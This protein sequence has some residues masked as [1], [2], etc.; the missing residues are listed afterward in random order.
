ML[1]RAAVS[2]LILAVGSGVLVAASSMRDSP[3]AQTPTS[4]QTYIAR[5]SPA[6]S[7]SSP[8]RSCVPRP[9]ACGFPDQTNTGVR[10][11]TRLTSVDHDVHTSR[12]GE[13]IAN[14]D[15]R[16]TLYIDH[17][18]VTV[19]NVRVTGDGGYSWAIWVGEENPV[20]DVTIR[21]CTVD[22][23]GS[24]QG[25]VTA[26][27][28]RSWTMYGCDISN[29]ENAVRTGGN[30]VLRDNYFHDFFSTSEDPHYDAVE[31]YSGTSSH[32]VHNT[33]ILDRAETSVVNVQAAFGP[34]RDTDISDNLIDGG[35]WQL[36]IRDLDGPVRGTRVDGN[37]FGHRRLYGHAA[38][39][40]G[41]VTSIRGNVEDDTGA[42]LDSGL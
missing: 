34:I 5:P 32:L 22:A 2:L 14:L 9:S 3:S 21:D 24:D 19:E 40:K 13:L 28:A 12:D 6:V 25:G 35:G 37:R 20:A 26:G 30:V 29:G 7:T 33:M 42:N 36:N 41:T 17:S 8:Q 31:V 39:D 1:K 16:G 38:I 23:N 10:P 15:I 18:R 4:A 11:G 27:A